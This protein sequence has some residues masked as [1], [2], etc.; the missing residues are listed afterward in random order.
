[1]YFSYYITLLYD[2]I[3]DML[4]FMNDNIGISVKVS[5]VTLYCLASKLSYARVE[6]VSEGLFL[7]ISTTGEIQKPIV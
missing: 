2:N 3:Y 6:T 7:D 5:L 4:A 1:M